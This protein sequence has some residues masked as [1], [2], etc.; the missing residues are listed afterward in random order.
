MAAICTASRIESAHVFFV[1]R[2]L[3]EQKQNLRQA[4]IVYN[5]L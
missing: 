2:S 4:L 3:T 5:F 1:R